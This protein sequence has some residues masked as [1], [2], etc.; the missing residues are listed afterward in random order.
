MS[1]SAPAPRDSPTLTLTESVVA[2]V[3]LNGIIW[4]FTSTGGIIRMTPNPLNIERIYTLPSTMLRAPATLGVT[5]V[6]AGVSAPSHYA[7][8]ENEPA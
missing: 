3:P 7:P 6:P 2:A 1:E 4:I 8:M 5:S